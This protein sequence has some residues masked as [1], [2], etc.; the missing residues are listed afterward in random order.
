MKATRR[1]LVTI[2]L[3]AVGCTS[4]GLLAQPAVAA[5]LCV[6]APSRGCFASIQEAIDAAGDGDVIRVAPGTYAGGITIAKSLQLVG[7]GAGATR[8]EGGGPVLTIGDRAGKPTVSI[9]RV[10]MTGGFNNSKPDSFVTFGGGI[11]ILPA[12]GDATGATVMIS[13]SVISANRVTP[14]TALPLCGHLCA[15]AQG[16]GIA[17]AGTLTVTN[18]KISDNV[19]G[20]TAADASVASYAAGGGIF[21]GF[22]G[23]L[24]LTRSV[25]SGNRAAVTAPNGRF[26]DGGGIVNQGVLTVEASAVRGNFSEVE[27]AVASSFPSDIQQEAN[28]GGLYLPQGSTTTIT[29]STINNNSV[30]SS[31]AAGDA[32][33]E[34]GGIDSDGSLLL[35]RTSVDHNTATGTVPASSG[36]LVEA[37]GGGIQVQGVTTLRDSRVL[38]NRLSAT[39][40]TGAA[41]ASGGGLF[42]LGGRLTLE[43]AVVTA[44]S[45]SATGVGG[46]NLG[47]GIANIQFGGPLP[48]LTL[49]DSVITANTL[50]ASAGITSQGGGLYTVDPFSGEPFPVTLTRTVIEGNKPDQCVGC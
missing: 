19:A 25:V 14:Q 44:N 38:D 5:T 20:S 50:T 27:A 33:A 31:N 26:S 39:S 12:T 43:R 6:G 34:A 46:F 40:E 30:G 41:L 7:S 32:V 16:G 23:T 47:G 24:T 42:N 2:L 18:T 22:Q 45:A 10:T 1:A 11:S 8:I 35:T 48:E 3:A 9:S 49:T 15:F 28:A 29:S 36:F 37:D 21:N 17:N 13:D 4:L